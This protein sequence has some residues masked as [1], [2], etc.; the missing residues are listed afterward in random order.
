MNGVHDFGGMHGYGPVHP[1]PDEPPFHADWEKRALALTLAMGATG[2]WNI[3][4]SRSARESLP[5]A[6]YL[7][8]SYYQIWL[9]GLES[10]MLQRG[11][12]SAEEIAQGHLRHPA[13]P[14]AGRLAATDV[15]AVLAR[16]ASTERE[17]AQPARFAAGDR[18]RMNNLHPKA[19]TRLPRYVR[20]H[21]G[22]VE[23]VRGCH[24]FADRHA[25]GDATPE[26]LYTVSFTGEE[27]WGP[28]SEPGVRVSVDAWEPYMELDRG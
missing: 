27:L 12:V 18:V 11:L 14:I 28:S 21:A 15:A 26:W 23:A 22:V 9:A 6:Q 13:A 10:L 20:N 4:M 7:S 19:H 1:E 16:G 17:A 3:D 5:A 2:Q 24:V 8:S 25:L